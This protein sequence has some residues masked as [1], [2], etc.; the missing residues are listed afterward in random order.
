MMNTA[1]PQLLGIAGALA[2]AAGAVMA[3][4]FADA[5]PPLSRQQCD[6]LVQQGNYKDAFEGYR[7]LAL[8]SKNDPALVGRDLQEAI[9]CLARLQRLDEIDSFRDSVIEIHK[10]NWR[11]LQT[12]A[13]TLL[14]EQQH[15]GFIVAGKFHRGPHQG[16]GRYVSARERDRVRA[17][18]LFVQGLDRVLANPDRPGAGRYLLALAE[19]LLSS[20]TSGDSWRLQNLTSLESMP[21]YD[22]FESQPWDGRQTGAPV[23]ADGRPVLYDVPSGFGQARNDGQRW[24]WALAQAVEADPGLLNE[25]RYHH[26]DF[27]HGQFGTQTLE[28]MRQAEFAAYGQPEPKILPSLKN[29]TD[30]ETIAMLATGVK[31]FTLPPEFNPINIYQTIADD[32]RT[33]HGEDALGQLASMF[34]SR[35]QFDRAADYLKRSRNEYGDREDAKSK[36]IQQLLGAWGQFEHSTTHPA[37]RVATVGF[38]FRNGTRVHFEALEVNLDKLL[39]DAKEYAQSDRR[40]FDWNH[41]DLGDIG[42]RL[43]THN[44][45]Q[46][47][48]RLAARWDLELKPLPGHFDKQITVTTPFNQAGA[49]LLKATIEGGNTSHIIIYIQDTVIIKKSM[50]QQA[51]YFIADSRTGQPLPGADVDL[52]GWRMVQVEGKNQYRTETK[53]ISLRTD[54]VGQALLPTNI[55]DDPQGQYQWLCTARTREGR[56]AHLGFA[57]I[58]AIRYG[59][60]PSEVV[61]VH[62]ITDR[63]VYRPAQTVRFKF[64]VAHA[65]HDQDGASAFAGKSFAVEIQNPKG[66]KV[67]SRN[68]ESDSFGGFDGSFDLPSDAALGVYQVFVPRM[69]GGSFRVE[70]YKKP[71]FEVSI[72]APTKPVMLGEKVSATIKAKYFFGSPVAQAKVRYKITRSTADERWY[73]AGRWDWL[74]GPGYWW[75]AADSSWYPGWTLWGIAP[76]APWWWNRP[77]G[78]P[79]IVAGAEVSIRPDGTFPVEI[80]TAQARE[81]HPDGNHRYEI[82]A[83]VTDQS[84]RTILG[85]GTVLVARKPFTVYTW[86]DRGHYKTGDT[87]EASVRAQ[88]LDRKPVAGKGTLKLLKITYDAAGKPLE[89]EVG[90]WNLALDGDGQASQTIKASAPGQY[91]FSA[92]IDDGQGHSIEGGYLFVIT[93]QELADSSFL[94]NDLE[95]IPDRKE[96]RPG[97]TLRLLINTNQANSTVLLFLRPANGVYLPPKILRL[98][99]KSAVEEIGIVPRDMPNFFLEAITVAGGKVHSQARQVAVPPESRVLS[100]AIEPSQNTYKPGQKARIKV[101]L[102]GADGTP[103]VG[104]TVLTVYDKAVESIAGGSNVA[105]IRETFWAWKRNHF[106]QT[107]SSLE[108]WFINQVK[109]NEPVMREL[110]AFDGDYTGALD[111]RYWGMAMGGM[112]GMGGRMGRATMLGAPVSGVAMAPAGLAMAKSKNPRWRIDAFSLDAARENKLGDAEPFGGLPGAVPAQPVLRTNFADTAFWAAALITAADGTTEVEFPLPDSLT[113]WKVRSWALCPGTR[114]GQGEAEVITTKDLLI[115]LQAPRFF[116]QK[117]EVVLSA[118]VHN[119]LKTKKA[120]QVV[121]ESDGSVLQLLD[122]PSQALELAPG[123]E[124]RVDWRVKV[125]HEGQAVIRMKALADEESDAAQM[126]FP[127]YVHGM[128]K[129][130]AIAG[131]IQPNQEKALFS[132]RVPEERRPELSRLEVRYSPTLAGALVDALPYLADYPYGCTEQTLNR[133]LP[134]VITQKVLINLGVDLK[135]IRDRHTNLN[136]QELGDPRERASR[137][138]GYE[139]NPVFDPDEVARMASAGVG[140]LADMQ[141]S[142]GG[143]GWFSGFGELASAHTT[144][145]VVHGL[146]LARQNDVALSPNLLERGVEWLAAYQAKQTQLLQNA[147]SEVKPYKKTAD[148][149]DALVFMVLVDGGLRNDAMLGFLDRDRTRLSVYAKALFGLALQRLGEKEKLGIVLQNIA[150]YVVQDPENQTAY[151]KLPNQAY[152]WWWYGSEIETDA[153]YLKLLARSDPKGELASRLAKYVLNNR[154]HGN[155][156]NSTRD[157]AY[158]IEALAEYLRASGED[159]PDLTVAIALDGQT[160][161]EIKISPADLFRFDSSLV[162][163]GKELEPGSHTISLTRRGN[164]PLYYNA[165]LSNFT[166]EDPITGAGLEIKV[167]RKVYRLRNDDQKVSVAGGRGQPVDQRVE[168]YRRELLSAGATVKSGELLEIELEIESKN[169]YEYVVFEDFKAAGFEPVE[170]KSGYN[171][172]DIGAYVEFR[173]DRVAFFARTLARGAH[174][175]AYRLRAEIPGKFH[176]L[177]ARAEAMYAPELKANSDEV[178]LNIVD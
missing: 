57:P 146:Q 147:I 28:G 131:V 134:T 174:S 76:P 122:S 11:L 99:G 175:V 160:R 67:L 126:S 166:L 30:D 29:L 25:V 51:Y 113:T 177:P 13:Q 132:M 112:G 151:L 154:K 178:Q 149:I 82:T 159:R 71:E 24:R 129:M 61:K 167:N 106:P 21:D 148:D 100:L 170:V 5:K 107:E 111:L 84:R 135:A 176:A 153:F 10:E 66:E 43:V 96:Y 93:G 37:G 32:P 39:K 88:T 20:R 31:R 50:D 157:T 3:I 35:R 58:W 123:G 103:F 152:W 145:Q 69:G 56:L 6:K 42:F 1:V 127:A 53:A 114:V 87:I 172:N 59:D 94:F 38:R 121:L 8:D 171:G 22:E 142:D 74:F 133:F 97:D 110:A 79:E 92:V 136:S 98:H 34:E 12:A 117:D 141:L 139:H 156:W 23:E 9:S 14:D 73:P 54:D 101:K 168:H 108:R 49:Y 89:S 64:W 161:K 104:S 45:Q 143:W 48:G 65:R 7:G 150:Q 16:G 95:I 17:L 26:A 68:L 118:N 119:K 105:D 109:P 18:Q 70:E 140:R 52:F 120:V 4:G 81:T 86:L 46:Y 163:E 158:C 80:D 60:Q 90:K 72:E 47:L 78:P 137:R 138:K 83:E 2:L 116:V 124:H 44:Q 165:Y 128:L 102:T 77:Q 162:L 173:D 55:L 27:L 125:A 15:D 115:R 41:I 75:F 36:Q 169:D 62:T 130:E 40:Q 144:A 63:P 155:Y 85:T 91:R 19:T 33:G 164:G